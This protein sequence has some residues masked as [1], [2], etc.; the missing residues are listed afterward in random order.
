MFAGFSAV[1]LIALMGASCSSDSSTPPAGGTTTTGAAGGSVVTAGEKEFEISLDPTEVAA[2]D[3]TF[4]IT[5]NG[6]TV[7]EFVVVATDLAPDA[8]PTADDGTVDEEGA[9][10][11]PVDEV[12]DIAVGATENL[13]V[14]LEAG[15]Y[16]AFCNLPAHYS[17][18]MHT[19]FTVA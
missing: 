19:G 11:E 5:N 16:V 15:N 17:Q 8:L 14:P 6:T 3:V 13:D 9:G 2:G 10:I 18:G 1:L 4:E 7:H 12:E